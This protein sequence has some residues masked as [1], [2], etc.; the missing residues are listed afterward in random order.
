[1]EVNVPEKL[2]VARQNA[3]ALRVEIDRLNTLYLKWV[4]AAE[5]LESLQHEE[6]AGPS[7]DTGKV[8]AMPG[9]AG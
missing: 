1:M 5:Y 4:G 3:E 6:Q 8:V 2:A 9:K 7:T